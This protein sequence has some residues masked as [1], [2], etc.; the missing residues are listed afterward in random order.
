[1]PSR[2]SRNPRG[3]IDSAVLVDVERVVHLLVHLGTDPLEPEP[4]VGR[5][6]IAKTLSK[7]LPSNSVQTLLA[8]LNSETERRASD[9][10]ERDRALILTALFAGLR[11]DELLRA[12]IVDV[13][14]N[15]DGAVVDVRGKG[16]RIGGSRSSWRSSRSLRTTPIT[17]LPNHLGGFT[18]S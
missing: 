17:V 12:N 8:A 11:A 14:R 4:L 7:G 13:R 9:W 16:A 5:P 10:V 6:K 2:N 18:R 1:V 3:G 15:D